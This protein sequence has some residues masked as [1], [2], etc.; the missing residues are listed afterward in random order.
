MTRGHRT[1][2]WFLLGVD[3]HMTNQTGVSIK[4]LFAEI[5]RKFISSSAVGQSVIVELV[6]CVVCLVANGTLEI[7]RSSRDMDRLDVSI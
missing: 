6:F 4:H 2:E 5:A 1:G 7:S 3:P